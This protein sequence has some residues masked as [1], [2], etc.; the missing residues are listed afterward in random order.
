MKHK[1][2]KE[3]EM[4]KDYIINPST[5]CMTPVYDKLG[6]LYS[7]VFEGNK[8]FLVEMSP[9]KI[10][11][12]SCLF[13]GHSLT[14]AIEGYRLIVGNCKM[15]PVTVCSDLGIYWFPSH[16][17]KGHN[18]SWFAQA[19]IL[20]LEQVDVDQTKVIFSH[21]HSVT[22]KVKKKLMDTR[23]QRAGQLRLTMEERTRHKIVRLY[24]PEQIIPLIAESRD[25]DDYVGQ[26]EY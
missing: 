18:C 20:N 7:K 2:V 24:Q 9:L 4:K 14:G 12:N 21:G 5:K 19:H 25:A 26:H 23:R 16:R 22:V 15:A 1:E 3:M 11:E 6:Y 10:M 13:Y 8:V 17:I